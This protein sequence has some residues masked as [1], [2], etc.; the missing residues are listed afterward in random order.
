MD[1]RGRG[2][3]GGETDKTSED[4]SMQRERGRKVGKRKK[5]TMSDQGADGKIEDVSMYFF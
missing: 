3:Q 2:S 5:K 1:T 4:D